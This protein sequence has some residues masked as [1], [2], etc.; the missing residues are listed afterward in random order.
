MY[1]FV[2]MMVDNKTMVLE[3]A[4]IMR[5]TLGCDQDVKL[6]PKPEHLDLMAEIS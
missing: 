4:L 2:L 5:E 3:Q 1:L 6:I